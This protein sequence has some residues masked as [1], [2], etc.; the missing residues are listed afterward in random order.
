MAKTILVAAILFALL[1]GSV[2][3]NIYQYST[4]QTLTQQSIKQEMA[5][6]LIHAQTNIDTQLAYLDQ[7]LLA[8]CQRLSTTG[9]S[10]PQADEILN[11]L[12]TNNSL[13]I[14]NAATSDAQNVLV[15]VQPAQYS[16][17]IS[18]DISAQ[19]QNIQMHKTMRPAM[20]NLIPLVEGF[21]GVVLVAPIFDDD[22]QFIGALSIV[23]QPYQ[24]ISPIIDELVNASPYSMW[25]MQ[26]NGT[27]IYDPD[28]A[29]QGKNLFTDPIYVNYTEVQNF[30]RQV[31]AAPSGYGT[32]QYYNTNLA[33]NS[34]VLVN[35]EAYWITVGIYG[36]EWRMVIWRS[37]NP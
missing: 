29:Q 11:D 16:S 35:K 3:F 21:P 13:L 6:L 14:V 30:V 25:G 2:G 31:A 18:E 32:Y 19:E 7:Q 22:E 12:Y 4:N 28:P 36:T 17:I 33:D 10:G 9:L 24:L 1:V 15:A 23:I 8:A 34:K 5:T 20:S 26:T 27:L 37:I